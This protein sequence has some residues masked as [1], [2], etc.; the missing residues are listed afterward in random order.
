M[1]GRITSETKMMLEKLWA[2]GLSSART[3]NRSLLETLKD[4]SNERRLDAFNQLVS[5]HYFIVASQCSLYG[6]DDQE[7]H[8]VLTKT[9]MELLDHPDRV[10]RPEA[11]SPWLRTVA[12]NKASNAHRDKLKRREHE[13]AAGRQRATASHDGEAIMN[14]ERQ[15]LAEELRQLP[16]KYRDV[17]TFVDLEGRSPDEVAGKLNCKAGALRVRLHRAH[18][19]LRRRLERR[20]L[21]SANAFAGTSKIEALLASLAPQPWSRAR[22]AAAIESM[23]ASTAGTATSVTF[24]ASA[25]TLLVRGSIVSAALVAATVLVGGVAFLLPGPRPR[26]MR[27]DL[28]DPIAIAPRDDSSPLKIVDDSGPIKDFHHASMNKAGSTIAFCATTAEGRHALFAGDVGGRPAEV[29]GTDAL[30]GEP[31]IL[32]VGDDGGLLVGLTKPQGVI[33]GRD[34]IYLLR[35]GVGVQVV[36]PGKYTGLHTAGTAVLDRA[37]HRVTFLSDFQIRLYEDG[38]ETVVASA[39]TGHCFQDLDEPAFGPDSDIIFPAT[40]ENGRH[41]L[42]RYRKGEIVDI[43][44][45]GPAFD[46]ILSSRLSINK[47]GAVAFDGTTRE[48][49]KGVFVADSDGAVTEVAIC[50]KAFKTVTQCGVMDDGTV[51]L[52]GEPLQGGGDGIFVGPEPSRHKVIQMGDVLDGSRVTKVGFW[53]AT[54]AGGRVLFHPTLDGGRK[55][56]FLTGSIRR[57]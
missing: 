19:E 48:G 32:D 54:D 9:F 43:L 4:P 42:F 46:M 21:Y 45:R 3:D 33:E 57:R 8:D 22:I 15:I 1:K 28:A 37:G 53:W 30:P 6:L 5:A 18:T 13:A 12:R 10:R 26:P 47:A 23:L 2:Q 39:G 17:I 52:Y 29:A 50:G 11:L 56:L 44:R 35:N 31:H 25:M 34:G 55:A 24:T 7:M 16:T 27:Q 51:I 38:R 36:P 14:D 49:T 41:S 40:L 20:G